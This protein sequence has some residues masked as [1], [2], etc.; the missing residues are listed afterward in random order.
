MDLNKYTISFFEE[1]YRHEKDRNIRDRL[2]MLL[3]LREG[4]V[5]RDISRI[6]HVSVGKVP[7]W[8]KRFEEDGLDG[9]KDKKGR[10]RKSRLKKNQLLSITK[11]IDKGLHMEDGYT[12]GYKTKDVSSLI[13][14]KYGVG[15]TLR[16]CRRLLRALRYRLKVPR[17]R[18]KR[19][20]QQD[21][22]AFKRELKK[23]EKY[24]VKR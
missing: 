5:Q 7:Y 24:W 13:R 12:R 14:E 3:H 18:H 19:R 20:N 22:S 10:G 23:N 21:V 9:L 16:H 6:L 17:P 15:Y 4:Y 8:K 11:A 1:H 2:Q